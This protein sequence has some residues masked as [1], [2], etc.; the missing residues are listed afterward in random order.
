MLI[1]GKLCIYI[2]TIFLAIHDRQTESAFLVLE[3]IL[4]LIILVL[5]LLY[6]IYTVVRLHKDMKLNEN[7]SKALYKYPTEKEF[8]L[9]Y[10]ESYIRA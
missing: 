3:L 5:F 1:E 10:N 2:N 9:Y 4:C 7:L 8:Y 6:I